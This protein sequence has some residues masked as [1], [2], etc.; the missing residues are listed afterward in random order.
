MKKWM[1]ALFAVLILFSIAL[2]AKAEEYLQP[3]YIGSGEISVSLTISSEGTATICA[4]CK[5]DSDVSTIDLSVYLQ[6]KDSSGNWNTVE[7]GI[8]TE[9]GLNRVF[10]RSYT[11]NLSSRGSYRVVAY[12][13]LHGNQNSTLT[14][15][16]TS[17]Y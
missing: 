6:R 1:S 15:F 5:G 10:T 3:Y 12:F 16:S 7:N 4:R 17:T 14:D 11:H 13:T 8:W 2:P 9:A